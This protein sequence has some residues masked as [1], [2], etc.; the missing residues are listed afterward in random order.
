MATVVVTQGA[1]AFETLKSHCKAMC[2][3]P[4]IP[5]HPTYGA[6]DWYYA[7]GNNTADRLL[8][9]SKRVSELAE[10][11]E[12]RPF[13]VIDDGWQLRDGDVGGPWRTGNS[14]F[15][16]MPGLATKIVEAGCQPGIWIRPLNSREALPEGA[17]LTHET[18]DPSRPDA[19]EQVHKDVHRLHAWGYRLI[20][21]DYSTFDVTGL[22]GFEMTDGLRP[23]GRTFSDDT[24]TT[25]EIILALYQTIREAAG[26][27]VVIGCNTVSHLSAG[28]FELQRTG[29]DT[30]GREWSRTVK[31]GVN[32]LA[33]RG[34]QQ[35]SFYEVDPDCVGL[36]TSIAWERNKRWLALVASSGTP[37][38]VSAQKEALGPEQN[39][40]LREAYKLAATRLSVAE[41]LDW[42][43]TRHP[44][45][46]RLG[47]KKAEFDWS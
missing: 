26:D 25:A 45:S 40:A 41:P 19:L 21:H 3:S 22:W 35:G 10:S 16:D 31:M 33:F 27:S 43:A 36:T 1:G 20:K 29:D 12:N 24:R 44:L 39:K 11:V 32:T 13:S 2:P 6:N 42:Q 15:P 4:R 17:W 7:Y 5:V 37:L 47:G 18:L 9:D 46:W 28:L 34:V 14:K 38:F 23:K 8:E 30:S